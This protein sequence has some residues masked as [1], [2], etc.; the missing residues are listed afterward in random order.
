[1]TRFFTIVFLLILAINALSQSG[2]VKPPSPDDVAAATDTPSAEKLFNETSE[3]AVKKF[4]ELEK[5]STPYSQKLHEQILLEQRQLAARYSAELTARADLSPVDF[6]FLGLLQNL[7]GNFDGAIV[8][9]RKFLAPEKPEGE[10]PDE[11]KAQRARFLLIAGL[12]IKKDL[13][14][15]ENVL[16]EYLKSS[17]L[18]MKDRAEVEAMLARTYFNGK[19]FD[20]AAAHA[21][22]A[23]RAI[24]T[25]F[26]D[27]ATRPVEIY[28]VYQMAALL[29]SIQR[30]SGNIK[31]AIVTMED[32]QKVSA[33]H[34][35]SDLYF[36]ATD[37]I[38]TLMIETG[39]KPEALDFFKQARLAADKKFRNADAL[40]ELRRLFKKR[41]RHYEII[42]EKAPALEV[43]HWLSGSNNKLSDLQ[44]KVV[45]LDFWATWCGPCIAAFPTLSRWRQEYGPQ[46]FEIV[47]VTHYYGSAYGLPASEAAETAFLKNF[48]KTQ[49]LPYETAVAKDSINHIFY[50]VLTLP[51]AVLIDRKGVIRYV[52][53]GTNS[54]RD[55]ET[56]NMIEKLLAEK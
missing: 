44:G 34:D 38:V 47:G 31:P 9:F 14:E 52:T 43:D 56:A 16:A 22:E 45:L 48:V 21:E 17:P 23:Y 54:T 29:F 5:S 30:E 39:R 24:K 11:E 40:T 12:V 19:T 25:Y 46:G 7:S 28:K 2:R 36:S 35:A 51:T 8:S 55:D 10:K 26:E 33:F 13:P 27:P 49:R 15:A 4:R 53:A 1:M 42:Q 20:K 37:K 50:G 6:Y 3:Y 18:K 32:L 41:D